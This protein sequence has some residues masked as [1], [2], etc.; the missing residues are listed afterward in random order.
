VLL[1]AAQEALTNIRRHAAATSVRIELGRDAGR[2]TLAVT[3]DGQGFDPAS[4]PEGFGLSGL[5]SR[6]STF[7]GQC[8]V[9]S[10]PGRGTTVRLLLPEARA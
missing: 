9:D 2:A 5:R 6:A 4:I 1:R 7:G 10:Q 3:D 8:V